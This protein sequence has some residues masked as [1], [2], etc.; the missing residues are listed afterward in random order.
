MS[1]L[2]LIMHV[3]RGLHRRWGLQIVLLLGSPRRRLHLRGRFIALT[4]Y[5]APTFMPP[6]L[7][8]I[9]LHS[10][11]P[12]ISDEISHVERLGERL[13]GICTRFPI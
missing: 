9:A 1:R 4:K 6:T 5:F 7:H 10:H 8:C 12:W 3:K 13:V 2:S 11:S